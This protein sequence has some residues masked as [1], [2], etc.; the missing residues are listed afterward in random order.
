MNFGQTDIE[1]LFH[2][3]TTKIKGMSFSLS[4]LSFYAVLI[5]LMHAQVLICLIIQF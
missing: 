5:M 3:W 4:D 2:I 1:E